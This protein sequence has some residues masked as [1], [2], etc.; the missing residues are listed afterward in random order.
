MRVPKKKVFRNLC[1]TARAKYGIPS[2]PYSSSNSQRTQITWAKSC[3]WPAAQNALSGS[4]GPNK[5]VACLCYLLPF[6]PSPEKTLWFKSMSLLSNKRNSCMLLYFLHQGK[7]I[8][9]KGKIV[10]SEN[11]FYYEFPRY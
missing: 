6:F 9:S 1:K 2:Y 4:H 8:F 7:I 10:S 11:R 3:T 5:K